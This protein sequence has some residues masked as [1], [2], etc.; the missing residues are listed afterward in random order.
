[1][2]FYVTKFNFFQKNR[3]SETC[4]NYL[5]KIERSNFTDDE[6][7]LIISA[8]IQYNLDGELVSYLK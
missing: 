5:W 4:K 1:M 7:Q 2:Y 8:H 6:K 3:V